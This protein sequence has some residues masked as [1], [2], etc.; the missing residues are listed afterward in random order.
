[1]EINE[2]SRFGQL[3]GNGHDIVAK[4]MV[5]YGIDMESLVNEITTTATSVSSEDFDA[6]SAWYSEACLFAFNLA[7][8]YDTTLDIAAAVIAAVS[9]RMPWKRNK[10]VAEAILWEYVKYDDL[11]AIDAAKQIGLAL[12]ANVAMAI[13]IAR[14]ESISDTLT[15]TKRRSFYNNIAHPL[16]IDSVTIDTW[17]M[18]AYCNVTGSVKK[19]AEKFIRANETALGGTGAGYYVLAEATR[20]VAK[21]LGTTANAIQAVY[22]VCVSGSMNGGREDIN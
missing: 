12:S 1:M 19:D 17:M 4:A 16:G 14:G 8:K 5:T 20:I 11:S 9:P 22:W 21:N 7:T 10:S 18:M 15:G 6:A 2:I 3:V 13:K